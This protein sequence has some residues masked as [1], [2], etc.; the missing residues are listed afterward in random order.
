MRPS[1]A[2]SLVVCFI[3]LSGNLLFKLSQYIINTCDEHSNK[4]EYGIY[5]VL[6]FPFDVG[7][8]YLLCLLISTRRFHL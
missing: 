7:M 4:S 1:K 2:G 6:N 3:P 5:E 8:E